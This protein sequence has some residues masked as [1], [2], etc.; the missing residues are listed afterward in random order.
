MATREG[1]VIACHGRHLLVEVDPGS[2][3]S[4]VT[5]SRR[6]GIACGDRVTVKATS[7]DKGVIETVAPR[8]SVFYRRDGKRT[9]ILAAN[10]NLVV[11]MFAVAPAPHEDLLDRCLAAAEQAGSEVLLVFNKTDLGDPGMRIA[12][13]AARYRRLG[14]SVLELSPKHSIDAFRRALQDRLSVLVGQSGVGKS[15]L[16]N[17]LIATAG[18]RAAATSAGNDKGRHTTTHTQLYRL[19]ARSALIDSPGLQ[20]FGLSHLAPADLACGFVEFRALL[21][22]CRFSNCAH[23]GEPGCALEQAARTGT[24]ERRRLESYRRI[25]ATITGKPPHGRV[26]PTSSPP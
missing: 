3:L 16:I 10:V 6:G 5:R 2:I 23:R 24:I 17:R 22:Q 19:D 1:E 25:L 4:C 26:S 11:I 15:T 13:T 8:T 18:A 7:A 21:G 12:E 9:K 20:L 14:Y